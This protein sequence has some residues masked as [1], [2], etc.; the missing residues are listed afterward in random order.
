MT[1]FRQ[2]TKSEVTAAGKAGNLTLRTRVTVT[3]VKFLG[4]IIYRHTITEDLTNA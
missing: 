2:V 4:V 3:A 1:L